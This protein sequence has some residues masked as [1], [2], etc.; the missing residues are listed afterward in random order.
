MPE[1]VRNQPCQRPGGTVGQVLKRR[2]SSDGGTSE[3]SRHS[4]DGFQ[5]HGGKHQ[6]TPHSGE[7]RAQHSNCRIWCQPQHSLPKCFGPQGRHRDGSAAKT[8]GP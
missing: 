7:K 8:V 1:V 4:F 5:A 2:E 6:R 3:M